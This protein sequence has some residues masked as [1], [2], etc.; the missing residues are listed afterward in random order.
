VTKGNAERR[1]G[2]AVDRPDRAFPRKPPLCF[3]CRGLD[4]GGAGRDSCSRG[5]QRR[6][7]RAR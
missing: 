7:H 3:A 5:P 2:R 6:G 4:G 1:R